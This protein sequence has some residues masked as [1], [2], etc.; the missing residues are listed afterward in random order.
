M[1]L[2]NAEKRK[3]RNR[4][5]LSLNNRK[6]KKR[7]SLTV[8]NHYLYAQL[9]DS[10]TGKTLTGMSSKNLKISLGSKYCKKN[11]EVAVE[12]AKVFSK[13]ILQ[14][15]DSKDE[16]LV[17]DRGGRLYHGKVKSFADTLREQ[18]LVF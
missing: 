11:R 14:Y 1:K 12:L 10:I 4:Y 18:G 2:D 16:P 3:L 6:E 17:F 13:Q 5:R 15:L 7:I 9:I 8:S